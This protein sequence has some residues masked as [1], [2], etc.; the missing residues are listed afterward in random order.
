MDNNVFII[1]ELRYMEML[2]PVCGKMYFSHPT[3]DDMDDPDLFWDSHF[4]RMCGW[5]YDLSQFENPNSKNGRNSLS[6]NDYKSWYEGKIKTDPTWDYSKANCPA[7]IPQACPV[8]G[9]TEF[10]DICTYDICDFCGWEDDLDERIHDE[11]YESGANHRSLKA[12]RESY[13]KK[14]HDNPN[15]KWFCKKPGAS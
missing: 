15:Y 8:C 2:C 5:R 9:K 7:P 1:G 10:A 3:Q 13:Q 11:N 4:C 12:A 14:I 6:L